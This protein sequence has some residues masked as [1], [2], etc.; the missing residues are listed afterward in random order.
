VSSNRPSTSENDLAG[1]ARAGFL[2]NLIA[3]GGRNVIDIVTSVVLARLLLP[4][5]FGVVAVVTVFVG[6]S[7]VIG[8]LGMA[9][10]VIQ[11]EKLTTTD[12][13][14]AFTISLAVG[15]LLTSILT[16]VS[17]WV[18][19][20][21]NFEVLRAAMPLMSIQIALAGAASVPQA[22]LRRKLLFNQLAVIQIATGLVN[23]ISGIGLA[24]LHF[25]LWSLV[26]A[27]VLTGIATLI[28]SVIAS[29]FAPRLSLNR[30]SINKLL[31]FGGTLTVKNLFVYLARQADKFFV[32]KYL[33]ADA[34]G[35]YSRSYNFAS[36]PDTRIIP[37]L[38]SVC[39]PVFS[40]LRFDR[41]K[42]LDWYE[43]I[44]MLV[45]V[46]VAP[47]LI[48]MCVVA[49]DFTLTLFG[50][51]WVGMIG[52]LRILAIAGLLTSL[53]K[54]SG[55][56]IEASGKLRF[57]ILVLAAY[58][59]LVA[60]G[61]YLG[62]RIGIE[63]VSWA[64]LVASAALFGMKGWVLRSAI[65]LPLRRYFRPLIPPIMSSL[66]M[67]LVIYLVFYRSG[68]IGILASSPRWL[69]LTGEVLSGALVYVAAL[70][71]IA[72]KHTKLILSEIRRLRN[73]LATS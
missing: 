73:L 50:P 52:A 16:A 58:S 60:V 23:A 24:L 65:G 35:L 11:A 56:A 9:G 18:S 45:A 61:A 64:I 71:L 49:E 70:A 27:P 40:R 20:F 5:E 33:G 46:G 32:P 30:E 38:Y 1:K 4:E 29:R 14:V 57:E 53:H 67:A 34:A 47:L 31:G 36:I 25:G 69:R 59:A 21:F 39:F 41:P 17:P 2:A 43:R 55:A 10:A 19:S 37:L 63:A 15:I 54:L 51:N 48:G 72:P 26:W 42:L 12:V 28:L 44:S 7:W 13:K 68:G 62:A 22:L 8:N 6:V 66:L 3:T